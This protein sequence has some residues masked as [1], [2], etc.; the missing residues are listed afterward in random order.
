MPNFFNKLA[1]AWSGP[2]GDALLNF[3]LY[4]P[5]SPADLQKF[6]SVFGSLLNKGAMTFND[7]TGRASL[8]PMTGDFEIM[9]KNLGFAISPNPMDP[10]AQLKFQ[11]GKTTETP[12]DPVMMMD[13]LNPVIAPGISPAREALEKQLESYRSNN[14][15]WYRP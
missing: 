7:D 4:N 5:N 11:F 6:G 15:Y 13:F 8:N 1:G 10:S 3:Q 9:G 2:V 14:P 12:K